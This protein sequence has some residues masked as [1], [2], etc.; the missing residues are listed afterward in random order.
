MYKNKKII[1]F[2]FATPDLKKSIKRLKQQA[3]FSKYYN[4]IKILGPEDLDTEGKARIET[5]LKKNKKRGFGY[6][7]W[8]PYLLSKIMSEINDEDIIHYADIGC[9]IKK[10]NYKKFY[11]YLDIL[12]DSEKWLL[13]FQYYKIDEKIFDGIEFPK[14]EEFKYTKADLFDYL[15]VLENK[16]ITHSPQFWAGSFF[17]KNNFQSKKFINDWLD[18]FEKRFDLIDDT[19][20]KIKNFPEFIENRHDQ[21]VYSILCKKNLIEALSA[22]ECDWALKNSQ[23]TWEHNLNNP[24]L[25]KRDLQYNVLK[26][27]INRQKK[28]FNRLIKRFRK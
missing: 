18:V 4:E 27:F 14:R 5:L 28:T 11:E 26:R 10:S 19:P 24:I 1:F 13:P 9:H 6:W 12:I 17:I 15:N 21:S 7:F 23:R 3:E 22:Y 2:S 16:K 20:S 8:K 25:A